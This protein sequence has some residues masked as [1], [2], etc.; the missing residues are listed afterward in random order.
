MID[1]AI[2][3][4][5]PAPGMT[6]KTR[7]RLIVLF[8]FGFPFMVLF[9]FL[10]SQIVAPLAPIQPLPN[11]NGY[12]D[13][14]KA[15]EMVSTN[16]WNYDSATLEQLR[17][18]T[19]TNAAALALARAGL[20]NGCRVPLQFTLKASDNLQQLIGFRTLALAFAAEGK[21]AELENHPANAAQSYLDTIHLGNE[22]ARGGR[23]VEAMIGTAIESSGT[24]HLTN[25]VDRLDA[26]S[27]RETAAT[28]E[29][30]D[31]QR[32]TWDEIMQQENDWSRRT[33]PG[34]KYEYVRL[35]EHKSLRAVHAAAERTFKQQQVRTRQLIIALA[36][37]AYE[38]DKGKPPASLDDLVPDYL[39]TIPQDPLTDTNMIY[40]PK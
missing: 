39:K 13:F 16:S 23:L 4:A 33:F 11:P 5:N 20:S 21:L 1:A 27:C 7:N 35:I 24:S 9:G 22:S 25:L 36:A 38:L 10:A 31:A 40:S 30:L 28:L 32:Q 19:E 12:D 2:F 15:A 6:I 8:I 18:T 34:V 37:R 29:I 26:K 17:E 14:V 3:F